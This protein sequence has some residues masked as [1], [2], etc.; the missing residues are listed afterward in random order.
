MKVKETWS[1]SDFEE[2]GWHDSRLYQIKFPDE[3]FEFTLFI[4]YIFKWV[5][6]DDRFKFWVS[7]CKLKFHNVINLKI[8]LSFENILGIDIVSVERTKVGLTPNGK[9][10]KWMYLIETDKGNISFESTGYTMDVISEPEFLE[11]Q[12]MSDSRN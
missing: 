7:P 5:E 4:D 8:D 2:M 11:S 10:T 9:M 6:V 1:D 3:K 12:D